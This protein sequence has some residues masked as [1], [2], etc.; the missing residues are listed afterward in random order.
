MGNKARANPPQVGRGLNTKADSRNGKVV[1]RLRLMKKSA[2]I[3]ADLSKNLP[4]N[5]PNDGNFYHCF[6]ISTVILKFIGALVFFLKNVGIFESIDLPKSILFVLVAH[7][8]IGK[9]SEINKLFRS[10]L[11][12]SF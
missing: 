6:R 3:D 11:D 5:P 12:G 7:T 9:L 4:N 10:A 2:P 8:V 1:R